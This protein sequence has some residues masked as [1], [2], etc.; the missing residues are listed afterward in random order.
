MYDE[1]LRCIDMILS[2]LKSE[3]DSVY[4]LA[5]SLKPVIEGYLE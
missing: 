1:V 5:L 3:A 2:A 4:N